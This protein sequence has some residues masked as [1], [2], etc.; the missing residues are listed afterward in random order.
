M[1]SPRTSSSQHIPACRGCASCPGRRFINCG[2]L[3]RPANDGTTDVGYTILDAH[4]GAEYVRLAYDH[5]ALAAEM[6]AEELP[7]PFVETIRTGWWTTCL[8]ILPRRNARAAGSR[9]TQDMCRLTCAP[10]HRLDFHAHARPVAT[11]RFPDIAPPRAFTQGVGLVFQFVG[12]LLFLVMFFICCG[13]SLLSKDWATRSELTHVG[14]GASAAETHQVAYSAQRALT[15]SV[16]AGVF[17][18]M[19]LAGAGLGMQAGS[20]VA[21]PGAVVITAI[22]TIFWLV[23]TIF[24]A[25]AARSLTFFLIAGGLTL[26]FAILLLFAINAFIEM[27][28]NPPPPGHDCCRR[29]IRFRILTT[30]TTRPRSAS[31]RSCSSARSDWRCSRR[32]WKRW[33]R[34]SSEAWKTIRTGSNNHDHDQVKDTRAA[35]RRRALVRHGAFAQSKLPADP[36]E[37]VQALIDRGLNYLKS[38]QNPTAAGS[39]RLTRRHYRDRAACVRAG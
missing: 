39:A 16:F 24:A 34:K 15:I 12:V 10:N 11:D 23:H 36:N 37:R 13:S 4:S 27:R 28:K 2:V 30:T 26:L 8:E 3:G 5:E 33:K 7:A 29:A 14:W 18:G 6:E 21:A 19:A 9:G 25:S 20:R 38:Q 17:F 32:N 35:V 22:G 31:P 1:I